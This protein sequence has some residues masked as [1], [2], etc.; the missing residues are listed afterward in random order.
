MTGDCTSW[1]VGVDGDRDLCGGF[2]G[3]GVAEEVN[4]LAPPDSVGGERL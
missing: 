1:Q 3:V 2:A 4:S